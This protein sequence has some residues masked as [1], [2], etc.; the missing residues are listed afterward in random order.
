LGA[1]P[2]VSVQKQAY[3]DSPISRY[4]P[5]ISKAVDGLGLQ[6]SV[7]LVQGILKTAM[8]HGWAPSSGLV[9]AGAFNE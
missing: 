4:V 3:P 6:V 2:T 9:G 1:K 7:S 5:S 8:W